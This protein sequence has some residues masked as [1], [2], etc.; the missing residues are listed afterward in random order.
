VQAIQGLR[1]LRELV[2]AYDAPFVVSADPR[3]HLQLRAPRELYA[4]GEVVGFDREAI[5]AGLRAWGD[6]A[7]RN[8][9]RR[10]GTFIEPGVRIDEHEEEP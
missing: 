1:K 10:S 8:R 9:K 6:I 5:E 2:E 4:V 3:S 7:V